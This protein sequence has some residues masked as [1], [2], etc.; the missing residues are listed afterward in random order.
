MSECSR[1]SAAHLQN[2][3]RNQQGQTRICAHRAASRD[4]RKAQRGCLWG[5][6]RLTSTAGQ[7]QGWR[8]ARSASAAG[9]CA[10]YG[11]AG[12]STRHS[13]SD[14]SC[15]S[16]ECDASGHEWSVFRRATSGPR[17]H[18][19]MIEKRGPQL[20]LVALGTPCLNRSLTC[21]A[22][23]EQDPQ[24][25]RALL[26]APLHTTRAIRRAQRRTLR[27]RIRILSHSAPRCQRRR[28]RRFSAGM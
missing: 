23:A 18:Q 22:R 6:L 27:G 17:S 2:R 24:V 7:Q 8:C 19:A 3:S 21:A 5:N 9:P 28:C 4:D 16:T 11:S 26:L 20:V 1:S 15:L 13:Q 12:L 25:R 10:R 14:P